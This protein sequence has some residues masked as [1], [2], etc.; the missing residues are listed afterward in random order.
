[1]PPLLALMYM[2]FCIICGHETTEKIPLGDHQIRRVCVQCGN[3]HYENPKVICGALA[4]WEDK[5]LLCRRAIE[6]RYGLW[7]LPAGYMEL[8]ETME[9]GAARETREEAEAE[10]HIEQLYCMYNIPRI[11][12]IYVLFK[13][14]LI[15]GTFGAGEESIE[16]RLFDEHEIPWTELAFPSVER[17]LRHY[18]EDRKNNSFIT[19]LETIGTRIDHTG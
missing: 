6:P 18:F 2:N 12:Q 7:T 16:C 4:L 10:I 19:H 5:V 13:A 15:D 17:T 9:Q 14:N 8:F 11:G 1:M 3:I